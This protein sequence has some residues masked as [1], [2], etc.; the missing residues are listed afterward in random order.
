MKPILEYVNKPKF[1]LAVK[2]LK[3]LLSKKELLDAAQEFAGDYDW[4]NEDDYVDGEDACK[5]SYF[6]GIRFAISYLEK[7]K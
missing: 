7:Q 3:K 4:Y 6:A 2:E 5:E 1:D